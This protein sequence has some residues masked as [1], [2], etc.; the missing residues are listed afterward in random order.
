MIPAVAVALIN[1]VPEL[2][3]QFGTRPKTLVKEVT[4]IGVVGALY[5]I[6]NDIGGCSEVIDMQSLTCV[7]AEHWGGLIVASVALVSRLNGKRA[8]S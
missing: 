5:L 2:F 3:K 7:S 1:V 6:S 4:S 8:E